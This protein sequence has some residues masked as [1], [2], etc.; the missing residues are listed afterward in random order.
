VSTI[1]VVRRLWQHAAWADAALFEA[2][3]GSTS[4]HDEAWRE[5]THILGADEVWL[6]RLEQRA[7]RTPVWPSL[8]RED[9]EQLRQSVVA[10]YDAFIATLDDAGL[11]RV[12]SYNT[13]DG[14]PFSNTVGDILVHVALHGQYH[15]GKV[16]LL[17]RQGEATPAPADFISFVRGAPAATQPR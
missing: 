10:G 16:N 2:L 17:L 5:Y 14:R 1:D 4:A 7:S 12:V 3:T 13:T 9:A 6:S 8:A 15:R 11:E